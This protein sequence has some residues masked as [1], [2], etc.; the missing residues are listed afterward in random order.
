MFTP[1]AAET[2]MLAPLKVTLTPG[3]N[4]PTCRRGTSPVRLLSWLIVIGT[5]TVPPAGTVK[6]GRSPREKSGCGATTFS[7]RVVL[8][9]IPWV[10]SVPVMTNGGRVP[11]AVLLLLVLTRTSIVPGP[12]RV[13]PAG[14]LTLTPPGRVPDEK[15]TV[16]L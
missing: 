5:T 8:A 16:P 7:V 13:L 10:V 15:A 2:I 1:F 3:G 11:M 12:V 6:G 14:K 4:A 9:L